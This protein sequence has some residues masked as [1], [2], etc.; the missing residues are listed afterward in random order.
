[1]G[2]WGPL[3]LIGTISPKILLSP[4]L[5]KVNA[6]LSDC[7]LEPEGRVLLSSGSSVRTKDLQIQAHL[8]VGLRSMVQESSWSDQI[9]SWQPSF[10]RGTVAP[11]GTDDHDMTSDVGSVL[12]LNQS[13]HQSGHCAKNHIPPTTAYLS[14]WMFDKNSNKL[15][16]KSSQ[17]TELS[18]AD[19]S[20]I[21]DFSGITLTQ[22][23]SHNNIGF[24]MS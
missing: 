24:C 20:H 2:L 6:W 12:N 14:C 17:M 4:N 9:W 16:L 8:G 23:T 3:K 5:T 10:H 13:I 11:Q 21:D 18:L 1:M 22:T 7:Y 15:K 19:C